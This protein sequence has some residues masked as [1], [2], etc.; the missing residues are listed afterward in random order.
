ME[1]LNKEAKI[2]VVRI[3]TDIINADNVRHSK[4]VDYLEQVIASLGMEE[5]WQDDAA[6]VKRFKLQ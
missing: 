4:E 3:L 2:A 1:T 6:I 5:D